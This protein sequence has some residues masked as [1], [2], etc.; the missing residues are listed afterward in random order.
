MNHEIRQMS[1]YRPEAYIDAMVAPTY[2]LAESLM[3]GFSGLRRIAVASFKS[4]KRDRAIAITISELSRLESH[5]LRDIGID[6]DNIYAAA[7]AVV[8]DPKADVRRFASR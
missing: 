1:I 4:W 5:V 7:V 6:R 8:D 3:Y 2:S